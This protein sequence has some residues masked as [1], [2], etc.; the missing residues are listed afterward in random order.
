[1]TNKE[2]PE[3][4]PMY[5]ENLKREQSYSIDFEPLQ[6]GFVK[7]WNACVD[8]LFDAG[9]LR[10]PLPKIDGLENALSNAVKPVYDAEKAEWVLYCGGEKSANAIL[11][12]ARAYLEIS[13]GE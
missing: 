4:Q 12:A 2:T 7:G 1:M 11:N 6:H 13:K 5:V 3:P 10:A 8:R 9:Y